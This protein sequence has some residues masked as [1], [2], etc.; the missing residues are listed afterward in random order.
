[1]SDVRKHA[2]G[3]LFLT[4]ALFAMAR[5]VFLVY[6]DLNLAY[7]FLAPD[8]YDW[9][10]NGLA[11]EGYPV[12]FSMR[13]PG[14]P[15][16]IAALDAA[17]LLAFLPVV[18]QAALVGLIIL[19]HVLL[20]RRFG[21]R[22]ALIVTLIL[23]V[24]FFLQNLALHVLA[25]IYAALFILA[26]YAC[27][28]RAI[29]HERRY[30]AASW[31][32]SL[33]VLFQYAAVAV[34]PALVIHWALARR[35]IRAAALLRTLAPPLALIGAW[36]FYR[37]TQAHSGIRH[38]GLL[39][40]HAGS[41]FFYLLNTASVL[42]LPA[43]C[44]LLAGMAMACFQREREMRDF[45]LLNALLAASWC[46]FWV[47]L[48]TWNDRRF[49]L[50]L[51]FFLL[52]FI[53]LAF[54]DSR[55]FLSR[56]GIPGIAVFAALAAA[57][58]AGSYLPY[59]SCFTLDT[60]K[61]TRSR[62]IRFKSARDPR[63]GNTTLAALSPRLVRDRGG[64]SPLDLGRLAAMRRGVNLHEVARLEGMKAG[65]DRKPVG[66]LCVRYESPDPFAWYI[67]KNRYG[68]YF[69]RRLAR[70]PDCAAPDLEIVNGTIALP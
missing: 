17:G 69:R 16:M 26:G 21:G 22:A 9:I 68:N 4:I 29:N 43:F 58:I 40:P 38:I 59:E 5:S 11:Y 8:S 15:L 54:R 24:N 56:G 49:I 48:Y 65:I 46:G 60:L 61:L 41:V 52:P 1:M 45:L 42:G 27:Y 67:E 2:D 25:D 51:L 36:A 57:A 55:S 6:P 20:A 12:A 35:R 18:T 34:V 53:A 31:F 19:N 13:A 44:L 50:Y 66:L 47:F 7:P 37:A 23:F 70:Q 3:A 62:A 64:F 14:L 32:L 28:L 10:A 30:I 63:T 33:S 39:A